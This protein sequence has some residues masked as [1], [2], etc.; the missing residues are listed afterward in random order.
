[1]GLHPP[2][3][4]F[5]AGKELIGNPYA[6]LVKKCATGESVVL[7]FNISGLGRYF[8]TFQSDNTDIRLHKQA[9]DKYGDGFLKPYLDMPR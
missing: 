6:I 8:N 4:A 1:M 5:I 9:H 7:D 2:E 3:F